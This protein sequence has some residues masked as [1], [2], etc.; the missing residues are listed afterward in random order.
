MTVRAGLLAGF[1][2]EKISL[3]GR[4]IAAGGRKELRQ[5]LGRKIL[6][7]SLAGDLFHA[8]ARLAGRRQQEDAVLL[9]L[10]VAA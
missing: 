9:N 6:C 2:R 5:R 10:R 3:S 4:V 8:D 1:A 7:T